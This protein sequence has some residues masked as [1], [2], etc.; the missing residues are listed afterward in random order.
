MSKT[1]NRRRRKHD[2]RGLTFW[3]GRGHALP[4][5]P[6]GPAR[7]LTVW[8]QPTQRLTPGAPPTQ[9]VCPLLPCGLGMVLRTP[10]CTGA[11]LPTSAALEA[12]P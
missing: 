10:S 3:N 8:P 6:T 1:K 7:G 4:A 11:V 12:G 9:G 5:G 2:G